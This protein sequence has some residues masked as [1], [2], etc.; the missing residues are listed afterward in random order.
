MKKSNGYRV[1]APDR[2]LRLESVPGTVVVARDGQT[3]ARSVRA[4]R[5]HE[6]E[7]APVLYVPREDVD[8]AR[9]VPSA[10]AYR[11]RWRGE[12]AYFHIDV[13]DRTLKDVAWGYPNAPDELAVL[14]DRLAFDAGVFHVHV[15]DA[16]D[17]TPDGA[18]AADAVP[19]ADAGSAA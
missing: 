1:V 16:P 15:E 12:A 8:V 6:G 17:P 19:E 18:A 13:R 11:C 4:V 3:I 14:R 9:L 10:R 7:R 5:L 2:Y